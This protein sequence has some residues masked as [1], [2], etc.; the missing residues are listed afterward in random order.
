MAVVYL[1]HDLRHD[2]AVAIKVLRPEL[3]R[4]LGCERFLREIRTTAGLLHPNILTLI[5]SGEVEGIPWY[6]I[7]YV[8]GENLRARLQRERALPVSDAVAITQSVASALEFAHRRGVVHRDVKPE[9]VMIHE[10]VPMVV[11]FGIAL[12]LVQDGGDRLT[13][14]GVVPGTP[15]YMSPEQLTGSAEVDGR[16]DQYSLACMLYEMLAGA[17][18][19]QAPTVQGVFVKHAT[20]AVP[21]LRAAKGNAGAAVERAVARALA[22]EPAARYGSIGEFSLA[23]TA[24]SPS[25]K[26]TG[27]KSIVVLPFANLSP[28][29]TNDHVGDGLTEELIADLARIRDLRVIAR[30]SAIRLKDTTMD[31]PT[32]GRELN[33]RY[34][35]G[36]SIRRAGN[37]IRITARLSDAHQNREIWAEK[38]AGTF[39]RVLDLQEELS[40]RIVDAL[41]LTL[42]SGEQQAL[43]ERPIK[44]PEAYEYF[45]RA[46]LEISRFTRASYD[47]AVAYLRQAELI[48]GP[49]ALVSATLGWVYCMYRVNGMECEGDA[50]ALAHECLATARR[51]DPESPFVE[52]LAG[53]MDAQSGHMLDCARRLRRVLEAIPGHPDALLWLIVG[54][55][56]LGPTTMARAAV[57]RLL[58]V[59]PL[60]SLSHQ[61]AGMTEF[62]AGRFS[63]AMPHFVTAAALEPDNWDVKVWQG[64]ALVQ[65]GN[66]KDALHIFDEGADKAAW[67]VGIAECCQIFRLGLDRDLEGVSSFDTPARRARL[68]SGNAVFM[69][70]WGEANAMVGRLDHA[71]DALTQAANAGLVS[72][73]LY[74]A[75]ACLANLR[76]FPRFETFLADLRTR[77]LTATDEVERL[78][79]LD[80]PEPK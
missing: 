10:G 27:E 48:E 20:A 29:P 64:W 4:A 73:P 50:L 49:N 44:R 31:A 62:L 51:L 21:P 60:G 58:E 12:A 71:V 68:A 28:D 39:D 37:D 67:S 19:F 72:Y 55:V 23:L 80:P 74:V 22:K 40:R 54:L 63:D 34:V 18:P 3:V 33:V 70:T 32:L 7:P 15:A 78:P 79:P 65:Q 56:H 43:A 1:A 11:D 26:A 46:R 76:G 8:Q 35:L 53:V 42:T 24:P 59:D 25:S 36:G 41:Q 5:D 45:G 16:S 52:L 38:Y 61:L 77:W 69:Y 47:R 2:R 75:D 66:V 57:R 14:T 9:N 30:S 6:V 13:E 17:P